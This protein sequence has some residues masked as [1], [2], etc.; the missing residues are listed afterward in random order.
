MNPVRTAAA[1]LDTSAAPTRTLIHARGLSKVY[2]TGSGEV[3]A[4]K[5]L[6]FEIYGG[7]FVSVVGQS[8]CG[9]STLL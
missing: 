8:G 3:T 1:S 5:G 6:D 7:E 4:L 2:I 9:K